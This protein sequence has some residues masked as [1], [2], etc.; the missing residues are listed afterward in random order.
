MDIGPLGCPVS[1]GHGHADLLSVQCSIFGEPCLVDAGTYG[2]TAEPEWRDYFR[3][4]AAHSTVTVDGRSQAEPAGPF[5]WHGRPHAMLRDWKTTAQFDLVDAQHDAFPGVSHRR[6]VLF[7]KPDFWIVIDDLL[8]N[9]PHAVELTYQFA[10]LVLR[11]EGE[12]G[13][14]GDT[15]H[16]TLWLVP[17]STAPLAVAIKFGETNPIRGWVSPDY[18]QRVAAPALV[19]S[20]TSPLPIRVL[21]VLYPDR[22]TSRLPVIEPQVDEAGLPCGVRIESR[23]IAARLDGSRVVIE[24]S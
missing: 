11:L 2:Y 6:R 4:T 7:V 14:R 18:G 9:G 24:K 19:Y 8:G 3:R 15:A 13:A 20:T 10:P 17:V 12:L 16:G 1:C 21:T 22:R 5:R 23:R